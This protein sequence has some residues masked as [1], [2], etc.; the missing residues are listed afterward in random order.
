MIEAATALMVAGIG[1]V[2]GAVGGIFGG[3]GSTFLNWKL[4]EAKERTR[5]WAEYAFKLTALQVET[6]RAERQACLA[7]IKLWREFFKAL[8]EY[9][10]TNVWSTSLHEQ[11]LLRVFDFPP[12]GTP[13]SPPPATENGGNG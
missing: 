10:R 5:L 4:T 13:K 8:E 7:P 11:G 2:A 9:D 3:V 6:C 1:I 12:H